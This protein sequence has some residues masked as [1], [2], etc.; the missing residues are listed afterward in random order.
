MFE[1]KIGKSN[2]IFFVQNI[3]SNPKFYITVKINENS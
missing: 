2:P 1:L 3:V